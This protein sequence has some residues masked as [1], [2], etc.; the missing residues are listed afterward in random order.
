MGRT[1]MRELLPDCGGP[2]TNVVVPGR[3]LPVAPTQRGPHPH[4]PGS[5]GVGCYGNAGRGRGGVLWDPPPFNP[6]EGGWSKV[7]PPSFC[8]CFSE[9]VPQKREAVG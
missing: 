2:R 4:R 7:P 1:F 5:G 8:G 3:K 6:R 9:H